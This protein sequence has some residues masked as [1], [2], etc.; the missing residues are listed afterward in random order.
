MKVK[1]ANDSTETV[2]DKKIKLLESFRIS[3]SYDMFRDS[4][5]W[6]TI[7]LSGR[8]KL[9]NQKL[10]IN[11]SGDLDPYALEDGKRVNKYAGGIGRLTRTSVSLSANFS[12]KKGQ[13]T[14]KEKESKV[15][16]YDNYVDFDVPWNINLDYSW[17]YYK[18]GNNSSQTQI[19]RVNGDFKLTPKNG[20]IGYSTGFDVKRKEV[21]ATQFNIYRDLHCWEMSFSAVPFGT[22][23]SFNFEIRVKSSLLKDLKLMK[24]DSW[25][26]R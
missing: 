2:E 20:K 11:F 8:T 19:F 7:K 10:N 18:T 22:H 23:Q 14:K 4:L 25:F 3:S 1:T 21:T 26:D 24:R 5:N 17:S 9:F 13:E 6:S 15:W 16:N 12:S